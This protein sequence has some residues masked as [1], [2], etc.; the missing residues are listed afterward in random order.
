VSGADI[1]HI[2]I[3]RTVFGAG[4][5][6]EL[7]TLVK[8]FTPHKVLVVSGPDVAGAGIAGRVTEALA[9]VGISAALFDG[10]APWAPASV[11]L[12]LADTVRQEG[13][14][15]LV[16]VGGGSTMDAVKAS[17]LLAA[18]AGLSLDELLSPGGRAPAASIR[19]IMV[20]TTAGS[21]SEWSWA[22]V[23]TNDIDDGRVRPYVTQ[24]NYPDAV[25]IDPDLSLELPAAT[26]AQSIRAA[27]RTWSRT[28]SPPKPSSWWDAVSGPRSRKAAGLGNTARTSPSPPPLRWWPSARRAWAWPTS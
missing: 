12:E 9:G 17:A 6:R 16:A 8:S 15:L 10:C 2:H 14:D 26:T 3:P 20:P 27:A 25:V 13:Y 21:G 4:A 22:A 5:V 23:V 18:D 28:C 7:G 24:M 19:K 11:V 1:V